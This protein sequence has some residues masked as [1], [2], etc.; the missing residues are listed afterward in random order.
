MAKTETGGEPG[1]GGSSALVPSPPPTA[2]YEVRCQSGGKGREQK[3][4]R[5]SQHCNNNSQ[6]AT[7]ILN[8]NALEKVRV[9]ELIAAIPP[10]SLRP[11]GGMAWPVNSN[12]QST[13]GKNRATLYISTEKEE[14][15][16][17]RRKRMTS[18]TPA[19]NRSHGHSVWL[20]YLFRGRLGIELIKSRR[21][22]QHDV[23]HC[24]GV[25][26][27][28]L[29]PPLED[30]LSISPHSHRRCLGA[31][32]MWYNVILCNAKPV[33]WRAAV[34]E[35]SWYSGCAGRNAHTGHLAKAQVEADQ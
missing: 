29:H 18:H 1:E 2:A 23:I 21:H 13:R 30:I 27:L 9:D 3:R 25:T 19:Q 17:N 6:R 26:H 24:G 16:H 32:R 7:R 5:E 14:K 22:T 28:L 20:P 11:V 12:A 8:Q 4:E 34:T 15:T 31:A 33:E 35:T 10:T